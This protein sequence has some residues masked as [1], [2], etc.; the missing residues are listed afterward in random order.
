MVGGGSSK[1][2][3][4]YHIPVAS[5]SIGRKFRPNPHI[6]PGAAGARHIAGNASTEHLCHGIIDDMKAN[7]GPPFVAGSREKGAKTLFLG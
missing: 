2:R 3:I 6:K 5:G 1:P 4:L 7:S